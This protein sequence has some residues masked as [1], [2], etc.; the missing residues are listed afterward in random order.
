[1]AQTKVCVTRD[2]AAYVGINHRRGEVH[3]IQVTG[4]FVRWL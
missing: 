1:M 3:H 2:L 4:C